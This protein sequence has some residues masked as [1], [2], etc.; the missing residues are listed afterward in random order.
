MSDNNYYFPS[1]SISNNNLVYCRSLGIIFQFHAI[2]IPRIANLVPKTLF[3]ES[4]N[5]SVNLMF[6]RKIL[7]F[8]Y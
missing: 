4:S 7:Q 3:F 5:E 1:S 2:R 8:L 6:Q